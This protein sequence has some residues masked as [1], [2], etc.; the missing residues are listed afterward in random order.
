MLGY[1]SRVSSEVYSGKGTIAS[2]GGLIQGLPGG[3]P[4]RVVVASDETVWSIVGP[5]VGAVLAEAS[6]ST[7]VVT[8]PAGEDQ[9]TLANVATVLGQ[10]A[11]RGVERHDVLIALGGGVPGDL[12]GYVAASYMRGIPLIQVPTTLVSQVDSSIGG[13]VGVDMPEGKNL[14][15]AFKHPERVVIDYDLLASLPLMSGYPAPLKWPSTA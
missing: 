13:K 14:V 10:L 5:R 8:L 15:G 4:R 1:A 2:L 9:K 6:L 12:F 7:E 3:A 11:Q